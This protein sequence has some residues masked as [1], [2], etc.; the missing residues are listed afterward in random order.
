MYRGL[1]YF[2]WELIRVV[3]MD[4]VVVRIVSL[5]EVFPSTK[6]CLKESRI[7]EAN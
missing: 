5:N 1:G 2:L 7:S 3:L 6:R 4:L